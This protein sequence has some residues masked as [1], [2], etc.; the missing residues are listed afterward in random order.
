VGLPRQYVG[1]SRDQVVYRRLLW[2]GTARLH[3]HTGLRRHDPPQFRRWR[4][5][6]RQW[7]IGPSSQCYFDDC[8]FHYNGL[9]NLQG[10]T[11]GDPLHG[12]D[13]LQPG[14]RYLLDYEQGGDLPLPSVAAWG[15]GSTLVFG[16][17]AGSAPVRF[18]PADGETL[19]GQLLGSLPFDNDREVVRFRSTSTGWVY[20]SWIN[21]QGADMIGIGLSFRRCAARMNDGGGFQVKP[22][23]ISVPFSM[24]TAYGA[25]ALVHDDGVIYR[26]RSDNNQGHR[27]AGHSDEWEPNSPTH[28]ADISFLDCIAEDTYRANGFGIVNAGSS[29][30][31]AL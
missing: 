23:D 22:A 25:G 28:A 16:R 11:L 6:A 30:M 24:E 29:R 26:S 5:G 12:P 18:V 14:C 31:P 10:A 27:P 3:K 21:G 15:D 17:R 19:N 2:F 4:Q 7:G 13:F 8:Q 9:A 20:D 1:K